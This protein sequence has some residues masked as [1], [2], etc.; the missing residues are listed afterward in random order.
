MPSMQDSPMFAYGRDPVLNLE[1]VTLYLWHGGRPYIVHFKTSGVNYITFLGQDYCVCMDLQTFYD[2][3]TE[4]KQKKKSYHSPIDKDKQSPL[5]D[6]KIL[7]P[8]QDL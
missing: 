2:A 1:H 7:K 3:I 4:E 6:E 8:I 5:T